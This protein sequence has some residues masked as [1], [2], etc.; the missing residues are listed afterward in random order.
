MALCADYKSNYFKGINMTLL[1][2]N[3]KDAITNIVNDVMRSTGAS[4]DTV[5]EAAIAV[6]T[7][8]IL[9]EKTGKNLQT[10]A[11]PQA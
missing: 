3:K 10:P 4:R 6:I 9:E 8:Q 1:T 7:N 11:T 5:Q 2:D